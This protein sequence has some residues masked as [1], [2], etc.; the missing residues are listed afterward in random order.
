MEKRKKKSIVLVKKEMSEIYKCFVISLI[1]FIIIQFMSFS[2]FIIY[3]F[4]FYYVYP[5]NVMEWLLSSGIII[6]IVQFTSFL[7]IFLLSF[8]KYIS[9]ECKWKICFNINMYFYEQL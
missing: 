5:N 4:C 9:L 3:Y 1:F 8:I 7:T 6:G 2:F